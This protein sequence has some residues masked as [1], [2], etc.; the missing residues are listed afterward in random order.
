MSNL[1]PIYKRFPLSQREQNAIQNINKFNRMLMKVPQ[2]ILEWIIKSQI[3][4]LRKGGPTLDYPQL[5][6]K[7]K[8]DKIALTFDAGF[9]EITIY[10][11]RR[12]DL[13]VGKYPLLYFIHGGG[14]ILGTYT[15]SENLL[16]QLA[17]TYDVVCSSIEYHLAPEAKFPV[18]LQECC[19]G[20]QYLPQN[21][22]TSSW[23][24]FKQVFL[25]GESAGGNL[26]AVTSLAL[27]YQHNFTPAGQILLYPVTDMQNLN[28]ETYLRPEVEYKPMY[29][30][31]QGARKLY[32]RSS[33]DYSNFYF[34]PA[35]STTSDDPQPTPTLLLL[36]EK[37]ALLDDGLKY[38]Q[39]LQKLGG[40]I[41]AVVY[42]DIIH[43]FIT[44]VGDSATCADALREIVSFM[45]LAG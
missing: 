9:G 44:M 27:K 29:K 2:P 1:E 45:N 18:A 11:Y 7:H 42:Q 35:L 41:R 43:A 38:S 15:E 4:K 34:S 13:P 26:A 32:A 24:D 40:R 6:L 25:A 31:M 23:I 21:P 39:V 17:D 33:Q 22:D 30:S 3:Q 12:S 19:A 28:T 20:V 16:L 36:A 37:D 8:I 5:K 10:F 14:F